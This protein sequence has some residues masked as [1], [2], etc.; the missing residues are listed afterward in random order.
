MASKRNVKATGKKQKESNFSSKKSDKYKGGKFEGRTC[1]KCGPGVH[2][3]EHAN[4]SHCGRCGY[5]EMRR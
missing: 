2:M 4:R 3:A 5:M 1:P